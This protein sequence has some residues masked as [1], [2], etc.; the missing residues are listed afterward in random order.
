[1]QKTEEEKEGNIH[2]KDVRLK[3]KTKNLLVVRN[4]GASKR[5]ICLPDQVTLK[6]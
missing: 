1:M 2:H 5:K 3:T 4:K 6:V